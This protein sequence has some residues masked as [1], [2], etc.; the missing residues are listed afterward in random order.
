M[1]TDKILKMAQDKDDPSSIT[2]PPPRSGVKTQNAK[3]AEGSKGLVSWIQALVKGKPDTSLREALEEYIEEPANDE[4]DSIS[5]QEKALIS[6]ILELRDLKVVDVMV[7]RAD[8]VAI[9]V[10]T[11]Q[12][13][14]L[15]LLSEKQ[16]SR[17]PVYKDN[18]DHVLGTIHIKDI[19]A[20]LAKG[21][22]ISIKSLIRN[23]PIVSPSLHVLDLMLQMKETRKHM[24]LVV[25]EYGGIDGL[26][27]IGDV[28]E[29]IVGEIED[30]YE[31]ETPA[32]MEVQDDGSVVA[33]GRFDVYEFE[34]KFG[35]ILSAEEREEND[36]L[37]GLVFHMAGRIPARGEIM[38]HETGMTFE[39]LDADPR[40]VNRVLIRNIPSVLS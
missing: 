33:D 31:T 39:V 27:T 30:E 37:G 24:A 11:S 26:V 21:K 34:E 23:C 40:R 35:Q 28:L 20:A 4:T 25:D 22:T 6:N 1:K 38:T 18:L 36:T 32:Q 14:L 29:N 3:T 7:P 17:L 2:A 5:S 9:D 15:S 8:I 10:D 12:K 13:E 16:F 19:L